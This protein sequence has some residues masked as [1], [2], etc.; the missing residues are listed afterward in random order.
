MRHTLASSRSRQ[1]RA[2]S[3][4]VRAR[5][6][7]PFLACAVLVLTLLLLTG[8]KQKQ[9]DRCQMTS[10]CDDELVCCVTPERA[11]LGGLCFPKD[12][13]DTTPIDAGPKLDGRKDM[14]PL[15]PDNKVPA[16][17]SKVPAPDNKVTDNKVPTPDTKPPTPDSKPPT[18]D[19]SKP[20]D[21]AVKH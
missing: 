4:I 9:G 19:Q 16:P 20:A 18:P 5:G 14:E 10:D 21:A 2:R 8:C 15:K 17:D 3:H 7:A 1:L 6:A 12:K 11:V 13:C